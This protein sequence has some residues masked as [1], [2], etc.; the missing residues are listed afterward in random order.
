MLS[1]RSIA[2][3]LF[4]IYGSFAVSDVF[5]K[6]HPSGVPVQQVVQVNI[7]AE[8]LTYNLLNFTKTS[9][10]NPAEWKLYA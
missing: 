2:L 4:N 5:N 1:E 7:K 8:K 6:Y 10:I 3:L 9:R